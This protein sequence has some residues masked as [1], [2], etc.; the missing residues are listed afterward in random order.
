MKVKFP[1]FAPRDQ[2]Y[3]VGFLQEAP[4]TTLRNLS[5]QPLPFHC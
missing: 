2:P 3:Q 4:L 1:I 5:Y